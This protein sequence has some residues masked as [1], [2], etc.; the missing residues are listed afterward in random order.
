MKS[1]KAGWQRRRQRAKKT[2]VATDLEAS[3]RISFQ[4]KGQTLEDSTVKELASGN[5]E[6]RD[7]LNEMSAVE[8]SVNMAA[9]SGLGLYRTLI[10]VL[11]LYIDF[12]IRCIVSLCLNGI[13]SKL[14]RLY[15]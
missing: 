15:L 7:F 4:A 3:V 5:K 11:W 13:G 9:T 10:F 14:S 2:D 8:L 1:A 6:H 12:V